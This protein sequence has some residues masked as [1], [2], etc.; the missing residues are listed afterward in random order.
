M[1][2]YFAKQDVKGT[3]CCMHQTDVHR[4]NPVKRVHMYG[5]KW[6]AGYK[7]ESYLPSY[8]RYIFQLKTILFLA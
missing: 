3:S 2:Q 7:I 5:I 1:D 6:K 8:F 4:V